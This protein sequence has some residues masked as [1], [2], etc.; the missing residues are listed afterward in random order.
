VRPED[1]EDAI[2]SLKTL[3]FAGAH[4]TIPHKVEALKYLDHIAADAQVI[5]AVNTIYIRN[6]ETFGENTDGK[7]F[8]EALQNENV[9]IA[10]KKAVLLG[11]GGAARAISVELANAGVSEISIVNV[12]PDRG[13]ALAELINERTRAHAVYIPWDHPYRIPDDTGLL[14]Q[15]TSIGLFPDTA[16]PNLDYASL[17]P[18]LIVCDIVPNPPVTEFVRLAQ[19]SRCKT[20]PALTC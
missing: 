20:F 1:L 17:R 13:L 12:H 3:S 19:K 15:A 10:G 14:I 16:R 5:G 9:E 7:G 18:D 4:I 6:H 11:A 2:R 8:L